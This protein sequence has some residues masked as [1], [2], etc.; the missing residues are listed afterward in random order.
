MKG[1]ATVH[2][3]KAFGKLP[4]EIGVEVIAPHLKSAKRELSTWIGDY[5]SLT[6]DDADAAEEAECCICMAYILPVLNTLYTE[7]VPSLQKEIGDLDLLFHN[8]IEMDRICQQWMDRA[9][10]AVYGL[11]TEESNSSNILWE[12]I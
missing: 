5:D 2:D 4:E 3:V 9:K 8:P 12:V 10:R 7:T 1:F 6:G 11:Q